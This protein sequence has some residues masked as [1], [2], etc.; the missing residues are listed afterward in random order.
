M[1][2]L[3]IAINLK[4]NSVRTDCFSRRLSHC[5]TGASMRFFW[6]RSFGNGSLEDGGYFKSKITKDII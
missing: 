2:Y 5:L 6:T 3:I 4:P 1:T